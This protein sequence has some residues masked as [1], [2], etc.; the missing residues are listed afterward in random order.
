MHRMENGVET[1][2]GKQY[3]DIKTPVIFFQMYP[4]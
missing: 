3:L 4:G 1:Q 2:S